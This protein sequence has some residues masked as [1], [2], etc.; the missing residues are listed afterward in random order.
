MSSVAVKEGKKPHAVCIPYPAQGHI[1]PMLKLAKLLHHR[2]FYI[3]FVNTEF[4]H[5]RLLKSRGSD[6]LKGLPDFQFQTIPD[7]LPPSDIDAT[8]DIPA[9][10]QST[11]TTCLVPF[12]NLLSKLNTT[13]HIPPVT[14]VVSD[15]AMSFTLQAAE[16][17]GV[18]EVLFWMTSACGFLA[19]MHYPH[20]VERGLAPLKDA[21]YLLNGYLDTP[22][23]WIP[24]MNGIRLKD[25]PTFVRTTNP[26][27]VML[28]FVKGEVGRAYKASAIIL[29]TFEILEKD[30]V[31]ALSTMLP[32]VYT[33]GPLP[34]MLDQIKDDR[35]SSIGSNLWKEESECL[36]WLDSKEPSSVVYVN[37]GSITVMTPQQLVEFAWGL[38]NSNHTFLWIIRPDLV[39]GDSAV[40]PSEFVSQ[41]KERGMLSSWCPQEKVLNHPAIGGFLT[42][43]GWN[44]TLESICGGVPMVCWPFFAEQQTNCRYSC[45]HWGIG[46]EMDNN[47]KRDEVEKL[48]RELMEGDKGK[49]M[50]TKA[51]VW[52]KKAEEATSP[53]GSSLLNFDNLVDE[54]L[55][56][57]RLLP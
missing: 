47:V 10:C 51:M 40:L 36:E 9:L 38:S 7:G 26:D 11:S 16:E 19:C 56:S 3:T 45:T 24:G 50:K 8:Q 5:K 42:H 25:I 46:T 23:D 20:L 14:C 39:E 57:N 12:R 37:F 31:D 55:L 53:D 54:I 43:S 35:L 17:I 22:L 49:E 34:L 29:N 32:R 48:V 15:G 30:V 28:N 2:G 41:T 52:K 13:P 21:S 18:P 6:S 4:N 44:S 27:D 1:N 33:I